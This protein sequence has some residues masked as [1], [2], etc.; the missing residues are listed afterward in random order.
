MLHHFFGVGKHMSALEYLVWI[1]IVG[2]SCFIFIRLKWIYESKPHH[3]FWRKP[4]ARHYLLT[5][6]LLLFAAFFILPLKLNAAYIL[7]LLLG[8]YLL[9][10]SAA[11]KVSDRGIMSNGLLASWLD[12]VKLEHGER[13]NQVLVKTA[14]PWRQLRFEVPTELESKLRKV[15]ASKRIVWSSSSSEAQTLTEGDSKPVMA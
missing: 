14:R 2:L 15:L 1:L 10:A 5:A 7:P 13:K 3:L 6:T 9:A 12:I 8:F 4:Q 11:V